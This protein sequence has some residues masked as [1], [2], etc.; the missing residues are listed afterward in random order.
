[1][2]RRNRN[3]SRSEFVYENQSKFVYEQ[4]FYRL[5]QNFSKK[6]PLIFGQTRDL[7][8]KELSEPVQCNNFDI[9]PD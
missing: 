6:L 2:I 9:E 3:E 1:M 5:A 4:L 7:L 8:R